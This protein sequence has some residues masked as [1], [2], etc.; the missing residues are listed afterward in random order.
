MIYVVRMLIYLNRKLILIV[1]ILLQ[2]ISVFNDRNN[3][4]GILHQEKH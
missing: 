1:S 4:M 3:R 2:K